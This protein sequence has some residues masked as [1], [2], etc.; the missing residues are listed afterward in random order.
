MFFLS[1]LPAR[2]IGMDDK[3]GSIEKG[4]EADFIV[5]DDECNLDSVYIAG[6]KVE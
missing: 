1:N 4:K 6:V 2:L 3:I 5:F